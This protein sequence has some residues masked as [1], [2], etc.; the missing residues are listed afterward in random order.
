[1]KYKVGDR[2]RIVSEKTGSGWNY[3]GDMDKWLGKV[4]TIRWTDDDSYKMIE[5]KDEHCGNGWF[6][7]DHMIEGLADETKPPENLSK[8]EDWSESEIQQARL[9]TTNLLTEIIYNGGDVCFSDYV[10]DDNRTRII[11]EIYKESFKY[12][13]RLRGEFIC[14]EQDVYNDWIGKCVSVC[15]AL[16][17]PI[18]DFIMNKNR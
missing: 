7:F 5:D 2:V 10:D 18:P 6:W 11:C 1:M 16:N 4:M 14:C 3:F 15:K 17:H 12:D 8:P 13:D 9:L